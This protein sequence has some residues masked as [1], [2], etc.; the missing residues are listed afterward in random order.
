[1]PLPRK[2]PGDAGGFQKLSV[3][4]VADSALEVVRSGLLASYSTETPET[5]WFSAHSSWKTQGLCLWDL[6]F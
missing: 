6:N 4:D 3:M 5:T 2:V 1:M